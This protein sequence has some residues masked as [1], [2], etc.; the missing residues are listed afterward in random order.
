MVLSHRLSVL[1]STFRCIHSSG[2]TAA[3]QGR[4]CGGGSPGVAVHRRAL[5]ELQ[6]GVPGRKAVA[7]LRRQGR[8]GV[9]AELG[10]EG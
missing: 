6:D 10:L 5:Q 7:T 1:V 3:L 8:K 9:T 4:C 2:L